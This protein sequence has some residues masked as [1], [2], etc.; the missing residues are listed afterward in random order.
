[1]GPLERWRSLEIGKPYV[2][3]LFATCWVLTTQPGYPQSTNI[4]MWQSSSLLFHTGGGKIR[5]L[6]IAFQNSMITVATLWCIHAGV[7]CGWTYSRIPGRVPPTVTGWRGC[8]SR[9]FICAHAYNKRKELGYINLF[10]VQN[11][12]FYMIKVCGVNQ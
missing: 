11:R 8:F 9:K 2:N 7:C 5:S 4:N 1:M 12:N 3:Q 6:N 10:Q